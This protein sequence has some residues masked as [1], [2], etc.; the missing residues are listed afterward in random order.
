LQLTGKILLES[1]S[2][3]VLFYNTALKSLPVFLHYYITHSH[4]HF[5]LA[6]DVPT[7]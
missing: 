1:T 2:A 3:Q 4:I 6:L 5:A 7:S